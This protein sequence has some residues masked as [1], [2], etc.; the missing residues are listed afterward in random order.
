MELILHRGG[1]R[2][3]KFPRDLGNGTGLDG[4]REGEST[5]EGGERER[6]MAGIRGPRGTPP[7]DP[8]PV[9]WPVSMTSDSGTGPTAQPS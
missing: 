9:G 5:E 4:E 3:G 6:P 8:L 7:S 2:G 1:A